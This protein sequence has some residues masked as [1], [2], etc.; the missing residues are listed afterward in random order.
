MGEGHNHVH[1]DVQ[2]Q[3][4]W[5][6][7]LAF[8]VN[9]AFSIVEVVA[10][11]SFNSSAILADAVHNMSDNFSLG[12]AWGMQRVSKKKRDSQFSYGYKRFSTL[13]ALV[14]SLI[15]LVG[16][17]LVLMH[18]IPI[19]FHPETS[20]ARGMIFIALLGIAFNGFAM[21][22]LSRGK[23]LNEKVVTLHQ[24]E[25]VLSEIGIVIVGVILLFWKIP[26]LDSILSLL[27]VA[28]LLY[29]GLRRFWQVVKVFLQAVPD[30][31][32]VQAL[33]N[34]L[35]TIKGVQKTH[36]VHIWSL[37]GENTVVTAHIVVAKKMTLERI[38]KIKCE[39]KDVL[40]HAGG[41]HATIE[42]ETEGESC[43]LHDC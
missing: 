9:L 20:N 5:R 16:S 4:S 43:N 40:Y 8:F 21:W 1:T 26:I 7:G 32:D 38:L 42:I 23:S 10:G 33:E 35:L 34:K 29:N 14:N 30:D 27:I 41:H 39:A 24:L 17:A 2:G 12:L 36:D 31:I 28:F 19:L 37:D 22:L 11:L 6:L 13:A 25:D 18:T 3:S 15:L